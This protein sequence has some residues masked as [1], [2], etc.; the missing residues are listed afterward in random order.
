MAPSGR[1]HAAAAEELIRNPGGPDT[2]APAISGAKL[3]PA[4]VRGGRE[5]HGADSGAAVTK[6]F[7]VKPAPKRR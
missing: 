5:G 6:R 7:V 3:S 4:S 1:Y 2:T